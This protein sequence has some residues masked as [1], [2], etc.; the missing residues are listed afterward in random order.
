MP[1]DKY[2]HIVFLLCCVRGQSRTPVPTITYLLR[3]T[4]NDM[5]CKFYGHIVFLL[6]CVTAGASPRPTMCELFGVLQTYRFN[7]VLCN[8]QSRTPVPTNT[9][10]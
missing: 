2:G 4:K 9:L 5:P 1:R 10:N 6:C 8:G 3:N 7:N